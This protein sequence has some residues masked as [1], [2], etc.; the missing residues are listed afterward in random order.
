VGVL[1]RPRCLG[2][3]EEQRR[4]CGGDGRCRDASGGCGLPWKDCGGDAMLVLRVDMIGIP[5]LERA[6]I[7]RERVF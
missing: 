6:K 7:L 4:F 3:T 5:D 2:C 1:H